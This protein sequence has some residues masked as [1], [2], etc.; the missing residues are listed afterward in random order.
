MS[1]LLK[2][3]A[4]L[5]ALLLGFGSALAQPAPFNYPAAG[6]GGSNSCSGDI[7]AACS[8][9]LGVGNVTTGVLPATHGGTGQGG[10]A[11]ARGSAGLDIDELTGHGNSA[12]TILST[13]RV[14]A[15]NAA[16]TAAQTWTLPAANS[17]NPGQA[18][19]VIDAQGTVTSTNTLT[20][21]RAGTDT[22]NGGTS[23]VIAAAFNYATL[24]SDGVSKWSVASCTAGCTFTGVTAFP[25]A[26]SGIA[27]NADGLEGTGGTGIN[28]QAAQFHPAFQINK[29][30]TTTG[31]YFFVPQGASSSVEAPEL[32]QGAYTHSITAGYA[33]QRF[34]QFQQNT[35]TAASALSIS[36]EADTAVILG[37]PIAAGSA[38]LARSIGLHI[39]AGSSL[40]SG[41]TIGVGLKVDAP[42]GPTGTGAIKAEEINGHVEYTGTAPSVTAGTG[43]TITGNDMAGRVTVGTSPSTTVAL[44]FNASWTNAPACFAQDETTAVTMRATT[45][46]TSAVTF[47]ASGTLTASDKVSY[48]CRGFF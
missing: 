31:M 28:L 5:A 14:V 11:A 9:V 12:Y 15:T 16:F 22:I 21:A 45:I 44:T 30:G 42:T 20:I 4:V 38:T 24:V 37:P 36:T 48:S 34:N 33:N 17:L 13:D 27:L 40:A 3:A 23:Y 1:A 10:A 43:A 47:T 19:T 29:S 46:S 25:S 39:Q 26:G 41:A 32:T 18:V 6:G 2:I 8:Q 35:I 7:N